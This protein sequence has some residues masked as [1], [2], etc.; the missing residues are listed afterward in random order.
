MN[1]REHLLVIVAVVAFVSV[2]YSFLRVRPARLEITLLTQTTKEAEAR[3]ST[4]QSP[5]EPISDPA[6]LED[7]LRQIEQ[8]IAREQENLTLLEKRIVPLEN[9]TG[10]Y[11]LQVEVLDWA[12][13]CGM[14]ILENTGNAPAAPADLSMRPHRRLRIKTS[15]SSFRK[16][17]LG[18]K[19][20]SRGVRIIEYTLKP[21]SVLE[22]GAS[23]GNQ[24]DVTLTLAL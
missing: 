21:P 8:E 19:H 15:F 1:R 5:Q 12:R 23:E 13:E 7:E 22:S 20:L 16:F 2:L 18:L 24:L 11:H 10:L 9:Q 17:L 4:M 6:N 3:L 14:R